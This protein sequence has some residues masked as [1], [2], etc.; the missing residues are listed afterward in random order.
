MVVAVTVCPTGT[1]AGGV[2][3]CS[4]STLV[5]KVV[6]PM[7]FLPSL[8]SVRGVGVELDGKGLVV[9]ALEPALYGDLRA[10]GRGRAYDR[11][12]LEVVGTGVRVVGIVGVGTSVKKSS[13]GPISPSG[14]IPALP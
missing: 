6:S 7:R 12:V 1:F 4:P 11:L 2:K 13:P 5:V 10:S 3:V 14:T 8:V 9:V